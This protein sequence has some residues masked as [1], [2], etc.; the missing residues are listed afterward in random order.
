MVGLESAETVPT[1]D[2]LPYEEKEIVR[3]ALRSLPLAQREA[4]VLFEILD[5]PV[6]QI[7]AVQKV[8]VSAV[9]SR[10]ARG[11]EKLHLQYLRLSEPPLQKTTGRSAIFMEAV[12]KGG[13]ENDR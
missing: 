9:K 8:S 7:A 13:N 10:L 4:L 12:G 11:R 6:A 5:L 3:L 1:L 2:P